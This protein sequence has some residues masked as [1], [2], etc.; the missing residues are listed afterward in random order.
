MLEVPEFKNYKQKQKWYKEVYKNRGKIFFAQPQAATLFA[1]GKS[2]SI[3][4]QKGKTYK[5]DKGIGE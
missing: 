2:G 1:D 3:K 4:P 5:K